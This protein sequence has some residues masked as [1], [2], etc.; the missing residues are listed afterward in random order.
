M[1]A[2]GVAL[3]LTCGAALA[4]GVAY[5][6]PITVDVN[7]STSGFTADP[8]TF[9]TGTF[10]LDLGTI[11][12]AAASSGT[13]FVDGLHHGTDYTVTM[14]VVAVEA[15]PWTALTTEILDPLSD[16]FD[17]RDPSPQPGYVDPGYSTSNNSDGLSF[18]WNSGLD[19]SATFAGGGTATVFADEDTDAHDQLQFN[20]FSGGTSTVTFGLRDSI[21]SRGFL[22][23]FST[24]GTAGSVASP[25]PASLVL[26]GSGLVGLV[27]VRRRHT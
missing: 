11:T 3:A 12:M 8:S 23:R 15:S 19:R 17:A 21:G 9:M 10:S 20:G 25:E 2:F 24:N 27:A 18:A 4:S 16:G 22:L 26:L 14:N 7:S 5:A 6:E 13:V 1:R